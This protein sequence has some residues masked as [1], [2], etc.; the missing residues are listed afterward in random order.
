MD[1]KSGGRRNRKNITHLWWDYVPES[2]IEPHSFF[3]FDP[4]FS[5]H[6]VTCRLWD[7][8]KSA[9]ARTWHLYRTSANNLVNPSWLFRALNRGLHR[10]RWFQYRRFLSRRFSQQRPALVHSHFATTAC[11]ISPVVHQFGLPHVVTVYGYDGS[12][13]LRIPALQKKYQRLFREAT[14]IVVLCEAVRERFMSLGCPPEKL[15]TWNMPAGVERYPFLARARTSEIRLVMAARYAEAKGHVYALQALRLLLD[16]GRNASLVLIG[17]GNLSCAITKIID[18]LGLR[19]H[20]TI[21]DNQLRGNF[22]ESY[23]RILEQSDLFILPSIRDRHG[24]DEAG[25]ALTMVCAQASG[26]P[27]VCTPFPGSEISLIPGQTGLYCRDRDSVSLADGIEYFIK[28]P[29]S[30]DTM[31]K[32]ASE[33]VNH[34]FSEW[35]QLD[36]LTSIYLDAM[37]IEPAP[38]APAVRSPL[39]PHYTPPTEN[40]PFTDHNPGEANV[41]FAPGEF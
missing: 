2:F 18:Q 10:W 9:D 38:P 12:A 23:R 25:P 19:S 27:A 4:N 28:H 31:G 30:L 17:Y 1:G 39:P 11:E 24:T 8:G 21:I 26:L 37:G 29:E 13:A 36:K 40:R 5:S 14:K 22:H 15:I 41:E 33:L 35:S 6:N 16:R 20:V 7:N 3:R 32:N 34:E